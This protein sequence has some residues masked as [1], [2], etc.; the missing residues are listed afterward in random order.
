MRLFLA[1]N[2]SH[3]VRREIVAATAPLRD[4]APEL[5]WVQ[6]PALH[7]TLKFLGDVEDERRA[8][9]ESA[10]AHVAGRHRE[11]LMTLGGIG[12]FPNF[13]RARVVWLGVGQDPRLE[14]LHHD[15]EVACEQVGFE[16]DGRAFR[17]HLTL[18][19]IRDPLPE[20]RLRV[21]SRA[22]RQ[23]DYRTDFIV[24]SIDLMQS[25]LSPAGSQ[26]T[27]V[28]SAALRSS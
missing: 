28:L 12:S 19:R 6:E 8:G 24:R 3:E 2:L 11:L 13:R 7:L 20:D 22:A 26:Y 27:T 16:L 17:P 25:Q 23:T 21:L 10:I 14:L 4:A 1:I 5:S 15:V 18:A 9:L